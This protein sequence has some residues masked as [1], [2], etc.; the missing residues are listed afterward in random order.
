M[1]QINDII[2]L[3]NYPIND[4]EGFGKECNSKLNEDGSIV[5]PNFITVD[6]LKEVLQEAQ[7]KQHLAFFSDK[8]HTVYLS[9]VDLNYPDN[10]TRNK[11]IISTKGC[12]TDDQVSENSALRIL[13]N[14]ENFKEFL[15]SVLGEAK[16]YPYEDSLSSINVH[17]HKKGQE[18][19][20]HFDNS[21]FAITLMIQSAEVGGQVEYVKELRNSDRGD[22]NFDGVGK[23]LDGITKPKQLE[24]SAGSL[25]LFRGRDT[26]HR[27][28]PNSG[29]RDRILVVLAYNIKP[30]VSLSKEAQLTFYGKT[31]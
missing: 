28:T 9:P 5:L 27:V 11:Q 6:A 13:Y 19:G 2:N 22:M 30:D 15:C 3:E 23:V 18:L 16:L 31:S 8:T 29:D 25:V 10:H 7:E 1:K 4:I 17:Y 14:S 21:A 20:W 24:Q 12:I 26:L